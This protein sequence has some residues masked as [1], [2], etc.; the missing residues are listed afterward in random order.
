MKGNEFDLEARAQ[1]ERQAHND[2]LRRDRYDKYMRPG[3][4]LFRKDRAAIA[5]RVIGPYLGCSI[6]EI[7]STLWARWLEGNNL[8]ASDL[9]CI[10]VSEVELETGRSEAQATRNSPR[11]LRMDAQRLEFADNSFDVVFGGAIL[12][13][14][15]L[16]TSM[17]EIKRV[18]RPGGKILFAEPLGINPVGR[19]VRRFTPQAR[20]NDERPFRMRDLR[21]I[22][23][24]F[25]CTYTFESFVSVPVGVGCAMLGV[26]EVNAMIK[27][28]YHFDRA[29]SR[30]PGLGYWFRYVVIEGSSRVAT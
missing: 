14:V 18:L 20:T 26:N 24:S 1:R 25:D 8:I 19:V 28:A 16:E 23:S 22:E 6:L 27:G 13:H 4:L 3:K 2:G 5:K 11:F 15:D 30:L 17:A 29:L 9:T 7:G 12:H 21:I 10:N